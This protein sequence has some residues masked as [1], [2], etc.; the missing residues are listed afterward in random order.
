MT[1]NNI[2]NYFDSIKSNLTPK[3]YVACLAAYNDGFLHGAWVDA[4]QGKDAIYDGIKSMLSD[5]PIP[6][7]EEW[8][9]HDFE[10]FGRI[11]LSEYESIS[12]ICDLA[13]FIKKHGDLG[14]GL[15]EYYSS[16]SCAEEAI[17]NCY[18]G[19]HDDELSFASYLFDDC[20]GCDVPDHIK[21]YIDYD[22]FC[23]D[24]FISDYFSIEFNGKS[25]IFSTQ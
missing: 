25:H 7:S 6:H 16:I 18:H 24:L 2:S 3:I 22:A 5:S 15:M 11:S 10:D 20:Y 1:K 17:E 23:R 19:E 4:T 9:I 14:L 8:A 13:E 21:Y 12:F